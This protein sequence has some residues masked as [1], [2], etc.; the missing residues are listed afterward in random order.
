MFEI[1]YKCSDSQKWQRRH[2]LIANKCVYTE[3]TK[4]MPKHKRRKINLRKQEI[5]I[6]V[7][8]KIFQT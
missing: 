7:S 4:S 1:E 5:E 3:I 6:C 2:V 8:S